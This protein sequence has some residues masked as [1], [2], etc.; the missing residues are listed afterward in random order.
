MRQGDMVYRRGSFGARL[1]APGIVVAIFGDGHQ[2][3]VLWPENGCESTHHVTGL[4]VISEG[5]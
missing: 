4:E 1:G 3:R 5:R 2:V